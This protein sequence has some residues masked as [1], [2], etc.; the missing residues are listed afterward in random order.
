M[1][2]RLLFCYGRISLSLGVCLVALLLVTGCA[3]TQAPKAIYLRTRAMAGATVDVTVHIAADANQNSPI[4]VDL[5]VVYDE[6]LMARL[7]QMTAR[8]WFA[9]RDQIRRDFKDGEG[10]DAWAWEWIPG[11][12]IP[13]QELPLKPAALGALVFS[14]YDSP[15]THRSRIDPFLD[16]ILSLNE[17][18]F[19]AETEESFEKRISESRIF[20]DA[21]SDSQ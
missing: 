5:L 20:T 7:L 14:D 3:I 12:K 8:E 10:F 18:G 11:Q 13:V 6:K 1:K 9:Q 15:G 16:I 19:T 2:K 4:A 17:T 21:D